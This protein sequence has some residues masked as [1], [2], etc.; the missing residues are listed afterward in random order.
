MKKVK[1]Q[2]VVA[3]YKENLW[4]V[5]KVRAL[6]YD[7]IVYNTSPTG[8][9]SFSMDSNG[10][11][12]D[13]TP[14]DHIKLPNT[15]REAGQW[16]HHMV[17]NRNNL[18]EFTLFLQA[19]LGWSCANY[20]STLGIREGAVDELV[21][22]LENKSADSTANFLSYLQEVPDYVQTGLQDESVYNEFVLPFGAAACPPAIVRGT[23]GGQF[24]VSRDKILALPEEYLSG[25]LEMSSSSVSP[26]AH[27]FEF[28]W[29]II[30]DA[31]RASF[32]CNNTTKTKAKAKV[33]KVEVDENTLP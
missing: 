30:M 24:R 29:S 27:R 21:N 19:D 23:I 5:E 2:I 11:M 28:F 26:L 18:A 17:H 9:F 22:W 33:S 4:W 14:I 25:L 20:C 16:L 1:P 13:L 3:S 32:P 10:E 8:I 6:G 7:V 31:T 12:C 15:D